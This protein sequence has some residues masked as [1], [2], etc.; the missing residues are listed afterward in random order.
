MEQHET[1]NLHVI[2]APESLI[3]ILGVVYVHKKT[4]DNGDM[5]FTPHG[6]PLASLLAVENWYEKEWFEEHREHLQG[7]GAVY[8]VPTK[9]IDGRSIELVVKNCRVGEDVPLDTHT[10]MEFINAEFNSPWEEF[11]LVMELREGKYGPADVVINTQEPLA[12]YVP[13]EKMQLWQS[14]RSRS[15]INKIKARHPGVD[16]DILRQY[17]LVYGWIQGKNVV[18]TFVDLGLSAEEL[19]VALEPITRKAINDLDKKGYVVADMKPAH[20]ILGEEY[21]KVIADMG[22][23]CGEAARTK[24]VEFVHGLVEEGNYSVVDYELLLRTPLHEEEVKYSR[25]HSYL[26]D[27]RDR[28]I[29]TP[30]PPYLQSM[31]V[32]GVPY[33]HGHVESTGGQLWVV[34]RNARLFD[35]FL[36]E[37]WRRTVSWRLSEDNEVFYTVT[38]D[39]VHIVWKT[40][41]V[42][43]TPVSG[44]SQDHV[45]K[46][47]EFGFNSPFEEFAIAQFLIDKGIGAVYVRAIYMTG[48][49]KVEQSTDRRRYESHKNLAGPNGNPILLE[50]RNYISIRGYFNGSDSWVAD[51]KGQLYRPID[52]VSARAKNVISPAEYENIFGALQH[53]LLDLGYDGSLLEGNDILLALDPAGA[54]MKDAT[55]GFDARI[56]NFELI[57]K[58]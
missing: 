30:L 52:L 55:G 9:T 4:I 41:R 28:L 29:P 1:A 3:S 51:Q 11:S 39:N 47:V 10:L 18:D 25:R 7:T 36:P 2:V 58:Q 43:E 31:E 21:T 12:I 16:L 33:I 23:S 35:Y 22:A 27:Q 49:E 13:P 15:K 46:A 38:K 48:S 6:L 8:R 56:C 45:R 24:Q 57:R 54:I 42:G 40:S 50:N 19:S 14:G 44:P 5:Y 37:R 17:K 26:D 32:F 20:V 34:G 53:R